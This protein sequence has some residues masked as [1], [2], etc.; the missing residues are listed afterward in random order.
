MDVGLE[1]RQARERRELTL[2]QLSD[3]TK[4][5]TR[6]LRAIEASDESC[7][8]ATVYTRA[9]VKSYANEVGLDADDTQRRYL[10]QFEPD[11]DAAMPVPVAEPGPA[12]RWLNRIDAAGQL[13]RG[14]F[15]GP[16]AIAIVVMLIGAMTFAQRGRPAGPRTPA[17]P[18]VMA[19]DFLPAATPQPTPVGTS[20]TTAASGLHVAFAPTGPCWLRA[21]A[22]DAQLFAGLLKPGES[23]SIDATAGVT[24]RIGDP[25][26]CGFTINGRPAR[27]AGAPGQPATMRI[28]RDNYRELT[29]AK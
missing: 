10:A 14:R 15:A 13:L 5:S 7:L 22:G 6:V 1:L 18:A 2:Q 23:R 24:L 11:E 9:F 28:T 3:I 27:I 16:I 4:I 29:S 8:P 26:A 25:A 21:T 19:A 20:G 17:Q 12:A